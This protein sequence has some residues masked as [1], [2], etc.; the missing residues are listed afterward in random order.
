MNKS[1]IQHMQ[2]ARNLKLSVSEKNEIRQQLIYSMKRGEAPV[3]LKFYSLV[4]SI[5]L[6]FRR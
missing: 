5:F 4:R 3:F 6:Y 1:F 2:E